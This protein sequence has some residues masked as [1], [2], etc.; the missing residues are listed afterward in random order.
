MKNLA[1]FEKEKVIKFKVL[2]FLRKNPKGK[3]TTEI[4]KLTGISRKTL[5][6]HLQVLVLE[7]E[8]YMKQYGPTRVYYPN[9]RIH[10][11]DFEKLKYNNRII[12]FDILENE[13][14]KYLLIQ[15]KKKTKDEWLHE[16]SI[17]IP[18]EQT[19]NFSQVLNKILNSQRMKKISK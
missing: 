14:G 4:C 11:L 3:T 10:H 16:H 2:E 13:Y 15:K 9:H 1:P 12:W 18:L 5:E 8:L 19:K 6:K 17:T 7:N